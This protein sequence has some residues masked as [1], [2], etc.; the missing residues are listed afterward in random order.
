MNPFQIVVAFACL[1]LLGT[2]CM[3]AEYRETHRYGLFG[4]SHTVRHS[5]DAP[6]QFSYVAAPSRRRFNRARSVRTRSYS[7]RSYPARAT[8]FG[9]SFG[10]TG[11]SGGGCAN[12]NCN[13]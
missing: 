10:W 4:S 6:V 3:A 2:A 11:R 5:G 9:W 1:L 8:S 13:R 7:T 12:G